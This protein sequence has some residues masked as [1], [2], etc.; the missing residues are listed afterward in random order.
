MARKLE[1]TLTLKVDS[2]ASDRL[3]ISRTP[4][5]E[6]YSSSLND[7]IGHAVGYLKAFAKTVLFLSH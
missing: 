2:P 7:C 5:I 6:K 1:S 4:W 3:Q